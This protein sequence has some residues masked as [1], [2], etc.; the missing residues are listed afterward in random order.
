MCGIVGYVGGSNAVPILLEGL[1]RLEYR[2][3]DSAGIAVANRR[4]IKRVRVTGRVADLTVQVADDLGEA[5]FPSAS[6]YPLGHA[7]RAGDVANCPPAHRHRAPDRRRAQRHYRERR[8]TPRAPRGRRRRA[9]LR[10]RHRSTRAPHRAHAGRRRPDGRGGGPAAAAAGR[11][12]YGLIVLDATAPDRWS[13]RA[14]AAR[15]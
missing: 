4:R 6:A 2:G 15:C 13:S 12:H 1:R 3:Y 7:R 10:H 5:T 14:T 11:G 8:R 9:R